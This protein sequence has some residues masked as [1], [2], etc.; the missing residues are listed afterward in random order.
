MNYVVAVYSS[1]YGLKVFGPYPTE[2]R[3]LQGARGWYTTALVRA[4]RSGEDVSGAPDPE[5]ASLEQI[6][7]WYQRDGQ[8]AN[9]VSI[10][11]VDPSYGGSNG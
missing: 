4:M 10:E 8:D 11:E 1:D 3:A 2:G 6:E 5:R 7:R 9:F